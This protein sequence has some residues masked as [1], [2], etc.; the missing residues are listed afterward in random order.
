MEEEYQQPQSGG[1]SKKT[2]IISAI[3]LGGVVG[4]IMLM[5]R[6]NSSPAS[7]DESGTAYT[8]SDLSVMSLANQLSQFRGEF[9]EAN[10]DSTNL[11]KEGFDANA[12]GFDTLAAA[13]QQGL[14]TLSAAIKANS[15]AN[16]SGFG[17]LLSNL[18]SL[19]GLVNL[20]QG[21]VNNVNA[22]VSNVGAKVDAQGAVIANINTNSNATLQG[23]SQLW[24]L[25]NDRTSSLQQ[26]QTQIYD[27]IGST[28]NQNLAANWQLFQVLS[29]VPGADPTK[30]LGANPFLPGNR[31][32][33]ENRY[34]LYDVPT[35]AG[36][37]D[38]GNGNGSEWYS[39]RIPERRAS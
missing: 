9:Q 16:A 7:T 25:V 24:G 2:I 21:S 5:N 17:S 13:N 26:G 11:I 20:L 22:N 10:A 1:I 34:A 29:S 14:D 33:G 38:G 6:K 19:G 18:A 8:A 36:A 23:L 15:D 35:V 27:L 12:K 31:A 30:A 37:F 3:A 39:L 4:L 28:A 32:T